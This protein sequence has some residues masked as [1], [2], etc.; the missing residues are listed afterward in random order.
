MSLTA[1]DY[2]EEMI[3]AGRLVDDILGKAAISRSEKKVDDRLQYHMGAVFLIRKSRV[4]L[5]APAPIGALGSYLFNCQKSSSLT[6]SPLIY[7]IV[8]GKTLK[9]YVNAEG[10]TEAYDNLCIALSEHLQRSRG[11]QGQVSHWVHEE[12]G[13]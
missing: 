5:T 4:T 10:F 3:D 9:E 13:V 8:D 6:R 7:K 12:G 2:A 1:H 11:A